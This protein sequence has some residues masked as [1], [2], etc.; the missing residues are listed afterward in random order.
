MEL[1]HARYF[2]VLAETLNFTAAAKRLNISQPP[3]SQQIADLER[4]L[5]ARLFDRHSR[6]VELTAAGIAFRR[7]AQAMVAQ[8]LL[9]AAEIKAISCGSSGI[10]NVAATSSVIFS[11]LAT[12]ISEFKISN[13]DVEI[14]I[15]ELPP[16]EQIE[17]LKSG[18]VDICFLR[19]AP[20]ELSFNVQPAWSEKVGVVVPPTHRLAQKSTVRITHLRDEGFVF[21]RLPESAF[22]AHLYAACVTQGFAPRIVQQ[23][24]EAFSVVSLVAAGLGIGLVPEP[25]G[26]H[27][28]AHYLER[29]TVTA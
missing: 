15:H 26:R 10:L 13:G 21:Y 6:A 18:R 1:R 20:A 27:S 24:V 19:F 4:Q 14:V 25:I 29:A 8:A 5:G 22:A 7:H 16:Q 2:L 11:G 23:V 9:A 28:S 12:R 3:L 17:Q